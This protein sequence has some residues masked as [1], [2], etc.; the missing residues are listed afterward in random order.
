[1]T[2]SYLSSR[3]LDKIFWHY[4][5]IYSCKSKSTADLVKK[6]ILRW[7][8]ESALSLRVN[9]MV[10]LWADREW[11]GVINGWGLFDEAGADL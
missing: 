1:M 2:S 3:F 7:V 10:C 11:V 4:T 5:Y 9:F 6:V 8:A